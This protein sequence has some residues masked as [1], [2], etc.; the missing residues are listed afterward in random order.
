M[1]KIAVFTSGGD[2]PGMNACVRAVVRTTLRH[3]HQAVGIRRGYQGM[4]EGDFWAMEAHSVSNIIQLGGTILRSARSQDFRTPEGRAKAYANLRANDI[5][6]IVAI[7]GDGSFTGA[8][9]FMEEY[10][11]IH[12]VGCPGTIDNDLYGTDYTIGYD[13][14]INTAMNAIDNIK[15]TANAHDRLFF[16][17]VMG[18]DA[19]FI[20][21]NVGLATGAEA[22][23]VPESKTDVNN[24]ID[25]LNSNY[26]N[27]KN[28]SIVVVAEGDESGGAFKLAEEVKKHCP[29][30]TKV[31]ILG[32]LQRGGRPT[33]MDRV[34]SSRMG[35]AA[36]NALLEGKSGVMIGEINGEIV[37]TPFEQ[38]IKYHNEINPMLLEMVDILS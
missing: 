35:V 11:D 14:A 27:K 32:H 21:M 10:P 15:D 34:R 31:T 19:G 17:E 38:A 4:I 7:G 26:S 2:A 25:T 29:Y 36:V 1:K 16:V 23:L 37:H 5:D 33:C 6:G 22:V 20:A 28:S 30:E 9:I 3:D 18:R 24:L 8:R 12:M 13:T